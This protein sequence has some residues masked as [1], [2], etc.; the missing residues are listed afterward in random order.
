[1]HRLL[2]VFVVSIIML[3]AGC[4]GG[5]A[6]TPFTPQLVFSQSGMGDSLLGTSATDTKVFHISKGEWYIE[7]TCEAL[8]ATSPVFLAASVFP[9]GKPVDNTSFVAIASQSTPGTAVTY[10]H[11]AG[12][13]YLSIV[14][15]NVKSWSVKVYQ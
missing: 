3:S 5:S 15:M 12:D 8:K 4:A 2:G 10:V 6:P 11:Q 13:F 7:T 9:Q 1:M 14:A